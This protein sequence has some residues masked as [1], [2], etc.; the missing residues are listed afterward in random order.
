MPFARGH[1]RGHKE[2][3]ARKTR[4]HNRRTLEKVRRVAATHWPESAYAVDRLVG[5]KGT[6]HGERQITIASRG[7]DI[8]E[9]A[10]TNQA[11]YSS[12][13]FAYTSIGRGPP[14]RPYAA[15]SSWG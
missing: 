2:K 7:A 12:A 1:N 8:I 10:P 13:H 11:S 9:D 5:E 6:F 14:W 4:R 15:W 3:R